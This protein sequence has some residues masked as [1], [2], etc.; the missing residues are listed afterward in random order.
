[1]SRIKTFGRWHVLASLLVAA[2]A[3]LVM[4]WPPSAT[5]ASTGYEFSN[6]RVIGQD[7]SHI[8]LTYDLRWASEE[9]PGWRSCSWVALD[10]DSN[11][12]GDKTVELFGLDSSYV[13]Q[14]IDIP[15]SSDRAGVAA[16]EGRVSCDEERL[17]A[18]GGHYELSNI[19]VLPSEFEPSLRM[20]IDYEWIGGGRPGPNKCQLTT[21]DSEGKE[22]F[23]HPFNLAAGEPEGK[24][25][26]F[27]VIP[28]EEVA[29]DPD[30]LNPASA[31]AEC[32]P[33]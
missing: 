6:I 20:V 4:I 25:L 1:M 9:F 7:D 22:I 3:A 23:V 8:H 15:I 5:G 30:T 21:F 16:V 19:R 12:V 32:S 11:Q 2:I 31:K 17:D 14:P 13:D 29:S 33:L 18:T 26:E 27:R 24:D 28:P 10:K